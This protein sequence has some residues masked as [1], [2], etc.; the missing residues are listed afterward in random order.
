[1]LFWIIF[2]IFYFPLGIIARLLKYYMKC[3]NRRS[4]PSAFVICGRLSFPHGSVS[5]PELLV[6]RSNQSR[7]A[8]KSTGSLLRHS[9]F[10]VIGTP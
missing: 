10:S 2:F 6:Q 5:P 1:M 9:S 8:L 7:T 3:K 4:H